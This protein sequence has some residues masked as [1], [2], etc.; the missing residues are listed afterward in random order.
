M[1]SRTLT[2]RLHFHFHALEKEMATY[3]SVLAWRIPGTAEPGGLPS[4]G[5]HRVR[6]DWSDLA[7]AAVFYVIYILSCMAVL[8]RVG[9]ASWRKKCLNISSLHKKVCFSFISQSNQD[10]WEV[11]GALFH[12]VNQKPGPLLSGCIISFSDGCCY[13]VAQSCL[14]LCG[15]G[16]Q[17]ARLP[18]PSLT[19]G[20]CSNSCPLNQWCHG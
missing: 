15:H 7:A 8:I 14:T 2:E 20:V 17:H 4:V 10:Q 1:K 13:S 16:L 11:G 12:G 6:H 9:K 5:S 19:P 18:C 3:S